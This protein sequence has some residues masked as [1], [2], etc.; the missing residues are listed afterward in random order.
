VGGFEKPGERACG[1]ERADL[2][3]VAGVVE[4]VRVDV[5]RGGD[6]GVAQDAADLGDVEPEV[7]DQVASATWMAPPALLAVVP[8]HVVHPGPLGG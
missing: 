7:D 4:E 3:G 2:G 6:A 1:H 5:E 8:E